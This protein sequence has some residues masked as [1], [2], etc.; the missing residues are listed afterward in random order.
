MDKSIRDRFRQENANLKQ[1]LCAVEC[2][3]DHLLC[4]NSDLRAELVRVK[5]LKQLFVGASF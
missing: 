4:E 5:V 2:E 1:S 3:R